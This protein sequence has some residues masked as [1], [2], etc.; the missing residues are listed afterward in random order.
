MRSSSESNQQYRIGDVY[1][2]K[3]DG[4]GN[5]QTGWRPG[6]VFQNNTGNY[7]SPNII[8]LPF[9]SSLKKLS[10]PTHVLISAHESGL[11]RDSVL[12]CE[13]PERLSKERIGVYITTL[14]DQQMGLVAR[15]SL[16]ATAAIAFLNPYDLLEIR[17][18]A[19]ELNIA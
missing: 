17:D 5:E 9:T 6:L 12:L 16:L 2:M 14:T 1:L 10:Q 3:F 8:A 19:I 15:A 4:L 11:S 7:Y 18:R 13:N